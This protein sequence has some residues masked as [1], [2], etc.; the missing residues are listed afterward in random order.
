MAFTRGPL[1]LAKPL[2]ALNLSNR[3]RPTIVDEVMTL[4]SLRDNLHWRIERGNRVL[5]E[6]LGAVRSR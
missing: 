2:R 4:P 6:I 5:V 3:A 1:I